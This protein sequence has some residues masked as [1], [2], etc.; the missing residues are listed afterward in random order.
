MRRHVPG[1]HSLHESCDARLR[2]SSASPWSRP[3]RSTTPA[4]G[5][6]LPVP[7][8]PKIS[9]T[10]HQSRD[11]QDR[12]MPIVAP[13]TRRKVRRNRKKPENLGLRSRIASRPTEVPTLLRRRH[14]GPAREKTSQNS[15]PFSRRNGKLIEAVASGLRTRK[16]SGHQRLSKTSL[17]GGRS[18]IERLLE[19]KA[20]A[21]FTA[22]RVENVQVF[23]IGSKPGR[24]RLTFERQA[25]LLRLGL[26]SVS[27]VRRQFG[28][29]GVVDFVGWTMRCPDSSSGPQKTTTTKTITAACGL[30]EEAARWRRRLRRV[31]VTPGV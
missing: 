3:N 5:I 7:T 1:C 13:P 2:P 4:F 12:D 22:R 29:T 14:H 20:V 8:R 28:Q 21:H 24:S 23:A 16:C 31:P 18:C 19:P 6:C 17:E 10:L 30:H 15:S 25:C 11:H 26:D 27:K 9:T